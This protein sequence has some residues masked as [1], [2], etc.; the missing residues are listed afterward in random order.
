MMPIAGWFLGR[1]GV[2]AVK[3]VDHWIAFGIL[4]LI[5]A[6]MIR[7]SFQGEGFKS[8][9][10]DPT[11]GMSLVVLSVATSIDA[12]AAGLGIAVLGQKIVFPSIVIGIAA[13]CMTLVGMRFG[14]AL[15]RWAGRGAEVVGGLILI[16]LGIKILVEHLA[17]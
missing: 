16:F 3:S 2:D 14:K 10:G 17:G 11:R 12:L 4:F 6:K 13:G 1:L 15:G 7:D 5:G 8:K 9:S